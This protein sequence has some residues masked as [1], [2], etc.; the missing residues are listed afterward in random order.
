M[1]RMRALTILSAMILVSIPASAQSRASA[2]CTYQSCALGLMP[3]W[4]GL[5]VT[6]GDSQ[7]HVAVL[8]FFLPQDIS[9]SFADDPEAMGVARDAFHMRQAAALLTDAGGVL[10]ATG[11]ARALFQRDWDKL[12]TGLALGGALSLGG[13]VPLQFAA[14]GALSRAVWL[15]NRRFS[16]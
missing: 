13:G 9:R 3:V 15:F 2:N 8:G 1:L 14:D 10:V 16:R 7:H 6:R 5:E 11:L 4:N 12:S